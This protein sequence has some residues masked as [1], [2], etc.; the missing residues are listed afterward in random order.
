MRKGQLDDDPRLQGIDAH[1]AGS[2]L[3]G[4]G[5]MYDPAR[6]SAPS[7]WRRVRWFNVGCAWGRVPAMRQS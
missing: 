5:G 2:A 6:P 1:R 7:S 4:E 3:K